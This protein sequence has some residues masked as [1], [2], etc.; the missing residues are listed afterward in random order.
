MVNKQGSQTSKL[1]NK[2]KEA[3]GALIDVMVLKNTIEEC[4]MDLNEAV[5]EENTSQ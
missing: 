4:K 3:V 1:Q 2:H 5:E